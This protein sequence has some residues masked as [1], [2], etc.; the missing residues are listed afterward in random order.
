MA[1]C[2][3]KEFSGVGSPCDPLGVGK[4]IRVINGPM[5]GLEGTVVARFGNGRV[6]L[7]IRGFPRGVTI[8]LG[9]EAIQPLDQLDAL[10]W[11]VQRGAHT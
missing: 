6:E 10:G 1:D 11:Q 9:R 3:A 2:E 5:R 4:P 8:R 7:V